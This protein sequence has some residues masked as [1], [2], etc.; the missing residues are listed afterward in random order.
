MVFGPPE[1]R[2]IIDL[3]LRASQTFL[4]YPL[5][6][7]PTAFDE[8]RLIFEDRTMMVYSFPLKHRIDCCGFQFIEKEKKPKIKKEIAR[9]YNL[10]PSNIIAL[11]NGQSTTL[12]DGTLLT[13]EVATSPADAIRSYSYCSDTAFAEKVARS[14]EGSSLLYHEATFLESEKER[15]K[16][17][18]HSTAKQAAEIAVKS[19][20]KYLVLGHFS[21]RY[22]NDDDFRR[23]A[24]EIFGNVAI[25]D[26]GLVFQVPYT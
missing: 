14:V 10:L 22:A 12:E 1:L 6:F 16:T 24:S 19:A 8:K 13:A 20:S 9:S 15:A 18:F 7:V 5:E 17:T 25:A 4:E 2:E 26:E 21:S 11:K 23:E 3:Q